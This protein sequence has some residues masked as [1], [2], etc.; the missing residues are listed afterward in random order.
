MDKYIAIESMI[1]KAEDASHEKAANLAVKILK[2]L[3]EEN[4]P[5]AEA[6]EAIEL[7][8]RTLY[9]LRGKIPLNELVCRDTEAKYLLDAFGNDEAKAV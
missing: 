9:Y 4:P 2:T 6:R 3:L 1:Q 8:S 7:V 5:I